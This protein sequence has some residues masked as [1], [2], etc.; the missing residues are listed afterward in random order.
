MAANWVNNIIGTESI[1]V[2]YPIALVFIILCSVCNVCISTTLSVTSEIILT[3]M[4]LF[5]P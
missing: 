3:T 1:N 4:V 5:A 2:E